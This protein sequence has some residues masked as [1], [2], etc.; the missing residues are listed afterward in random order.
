M[1]TAGFGL[2]LWLASGTYLNPDEALHFFIANRSSAS[3]A[4]K[5]SL[6]MAHPPLMMLMLYWWKSLGTSEIMLRLPSV[7]AGSAF[8]WVFFKWLAKLF[9]PRVALVGLTFAALLAPLAFLSTEVRQYEF[10]LLFAMGGAY[11][12]ELA[13]EKRSAA[14]MLASAS[15]FY[16]AM[17]S[18]YSALL[19]VAALGVYAVV[20][21]F[22][23]RPP[24]AVAAA[25]TGG[26]AGA[27]ALLGFLYVTHI[28]K[29]AHTTMAAQAFDSW[30]Y[31][32]YFHH[33]QGNPIVFVLVRSF[34]FFQFLLGQSIVGDMA[35]LMFVAGLV[36]LLWG[37]IARPATGPSSSQLAVLLVL[38]F[39]LNWAAALRGTYPYGGTRH[40]VFLAVFGLTGISLCIV[41]VAG[42]R[43]ARAM[44]ISLALI[45]LCWVFRSIRHPYIYRADQSHAQME[46]TL[47]FIREQ[48]PPSDLVL[49]D[50]ASGI[51]L[52]H[53]LCQQK[54]VAYDGSIPGF[55]AFAC[56][57]RRI[58]STSHDLWA[59][60][61]QMFLEE[62]GHLVANGRLK[63]DDQ[64]WVAQ[65]G[66]LVPLADDLKEQFPEFQQLQVQSFGK[67]IQFFPLKA[68]Q[69]MPKPAPGTATSKHAVQE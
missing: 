65:V 36:F 43:A 29:I 2:R 20:R 6:T 23:E 38:P 33:G 57:G 1:L 12:L 16:L 18:H 8:C 31:K 11:L 13:L 17:L 35:A 51:E 28:S 27:L 49:A 19:F 15:C 63:P 59:F 30:L 34:S 46:R 64:V 47:T 25:W 67:S 4:Y 41:R 45:L 61:T 21:L 60:N 69:T 7:L 48:M 40:C 44:V 32:S 56:G 14:F 66:W 10:M 50:Y 39:L 58:V 9:G 42:G 26:Q 22:S 37:K 5:A 3:L 62:W 55:L 24:A 54:P 53:Y 52:G 68:G